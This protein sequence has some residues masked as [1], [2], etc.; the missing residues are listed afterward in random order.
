MV[1]NAVQEAVHAPHH[2]HGELLVGAGALAGHQLRSD[3]QL[4]IV[5]HSED[6]ELM[7]TV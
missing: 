7:E 1:A 2:G 4:G 5:F 3:L 6:T